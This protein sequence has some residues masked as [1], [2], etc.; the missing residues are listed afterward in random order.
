MAKKKRDPLARLNPRK[1]GE[2]I[3]ATALA[4]KASTLTQTAGTRAWIETHPLKE[5]II[6]CCRKGVSTMGLVRALQ[7]EG[8]KDATKAKIVHVKSLVARES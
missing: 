3:T 4:A 8:Y 5:Q 1:P 6:E 2:T 7:E